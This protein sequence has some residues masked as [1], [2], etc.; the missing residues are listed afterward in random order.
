MRAPGPSERRR[1]GSPRGASPPRNILE[2][3]TGIEP[4]TN[5]LEG[6]DSTTELLPPSRL[7]RS[8][9]LA[10]TTGKPA[11]FTLARPFSYRIS[12]PSRSSARRR[13][14]KAGGEGRIRTFEAAGATDLQSVAFDRFAT[15]P[16]LLARRR[17]APS[18]RRQRT[19]CP[20]RQPLPGL[21]SPT[22]GAGDGK[23]WLAVLMSGFAPFANAPA[24]PARKPLSVLVSDGA[25]EGIRTPDR[26]ITNQ[27]LYRTELRQPRQ[28]SIC[29]T[30]R[31][32]LASGREKSARS[33][34]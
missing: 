12:L 22:R 23:P 6:C 31:A 27:L 24:E 13:R 7:A 26:L 25:G 33:Q 29:S 20:S 21:V 16:I 8:V 11:V 5:S 9:E 17:V 34:A 2:R 15:S 3:E 32:T 14:A 1:R 10:A 4:A 18:R 28:K 19:L 30:G